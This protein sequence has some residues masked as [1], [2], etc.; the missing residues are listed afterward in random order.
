MPA[1]VCVSIVSGIFSLLICIFLSALGT[2]YLNVGNLPLEL[3]V[4]ENE[5]SHLQRSVPASSPSPGMIRMNV[6]A[7]QG[8]SVHLALVVPPMSNGFFCVRV[9][10]ESTTGCAHTGISRFLLY[11]DLI[12]MSCDTLN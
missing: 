1:N 8:M 2:S 3:S 6:Q 11:H 12:F 7:W 9:T 4:R 5:T 10:G